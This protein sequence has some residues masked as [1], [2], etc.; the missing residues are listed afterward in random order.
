[1]PSEPINIDIKE[2]LFDSPLQKESIAL[3]YKVLREPLGLQFDEMILANEQ[4]EYHIA[5]F[6]KEELVGILLLKPMEYHGAIKMRQVA[7]KQIYQSMGIGKAMVVFSEHFAQKNGFDKIE[8][9]ARQSAVP[10]YKQLGYKTEGGVFEEVGIPHFK[11]LK[12]LIS[13]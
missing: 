13:D 4:E 8:L 3:R 5:A 6:S 2:L 10:F 9:N 12:I 7:V 1:M 11:M